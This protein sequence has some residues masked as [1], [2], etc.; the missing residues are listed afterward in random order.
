MKQ[1]T[2]TPNATINANGKLSTRHCKPVICI[3]TGEVFTS[4]TD[5][6]MANNVQT[7]AMSRACCGT[8]KVC[9]GKRFCF[10]SDAT[11]HLN[12]LTT[13]LQYLAE[14]EDKAKQW[15]ALQK[16]E[17]ERV[18][19]IAR[20]TQKLK[21]LKEIADRKASEATKANARVAEVQAK[22]AAL[23]NNGN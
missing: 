20:L 7:A 11:K 8:V 9:N 22:L 4:V 15:D 2:I 23:Q 10:L 19:R 21:R 12:E 1:I 13:R 18:E 16:A 17:Q 6:A 14:L 5:A 3:D